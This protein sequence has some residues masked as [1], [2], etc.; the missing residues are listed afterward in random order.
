MS[1]KFNISLYSGRQNRIISPEE[2]G[3]NNRKYIYLS[4]KIIVEQKRYGR[5]QV[6]IVVRNKPTL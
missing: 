1:L 2:I 5:H 6:F 3:I 4:N